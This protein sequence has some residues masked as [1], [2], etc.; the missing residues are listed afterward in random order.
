MRPCVHLQLKY[1][2]IYI[3]FFIFRK[4]IFFYHLIGMKDIFFAIQCLCVSISFNV[5][6]F[7]NSVGVTCLLFSSKQCTVTD[8]TRD[9]YNK[10]LTAAFSCVSI[11]WKRPAENTGNGICETLYLGIFFVGGG[12]SKPPDPFRL[13]RPFGVTSVY[14]FKI[15]RYAPA[16]MYKK[17]N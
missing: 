9:G 2:K 17:D 4:S 1:W 10:P 15:S 5:L 3:F 6:L 11:C 8:S 16:L 13:G 7:H 14:T 12:G